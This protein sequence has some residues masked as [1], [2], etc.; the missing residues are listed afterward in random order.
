M[1]RYLPNYS[2]E[3]V[4]RQKST[5]S[6][7]SFLRWVGDESFRDDRKKAAKCV[8]PHLLSLSLLLSLWRPKR[9]IYSSSEQNLSPLVAE[10]RTG[11]PNAEMHVTRTIWVHSFLCTS[12]QPQ[13][14]QPY[15]ANDRCQAITVAEHPHSHLSVHFVRNEIK[16]KNLAFKMGPRPKLCVWKTGAEMSVTCGKAAYANDV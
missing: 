7:L 8:A 6:A 11:Q 2:L 3:E 12:A 1:H 9:F 4:N 13:K 14:T 10:N 5:S 15:P 16:N